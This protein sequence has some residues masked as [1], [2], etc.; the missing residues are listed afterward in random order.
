LRTHIVPWLLGA[1]A[2]C[3]AAFSSPSVDK[4]AD[5]VEIDFASLRGQAQ[6]ALHLLQVSQARRMVS[7]QTN[8][9]EF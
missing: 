8:E 3:G 6:S 9:F 7:L 5:A 4:R 1:F 2:L